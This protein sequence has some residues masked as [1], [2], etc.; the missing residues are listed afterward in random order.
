MGDW[1]PTH[2]HYKGGLYRVIARGRMVYDLRNVVIYE[3]KHGSIWVRPADE[4]DDP[5]RFVVLEAE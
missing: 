4:F 5:E 2:R 1:R 3:T